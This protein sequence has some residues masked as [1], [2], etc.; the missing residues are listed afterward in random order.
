[1]HPSKRQSAERLEAGPGE[2]AVY[3]R[4]LDYCLDL[5]SH[6][7]MHVSHMSSIGTERW[8]LVHVWYMCVELSAGTVQTVMAQLPWG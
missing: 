1:M 3:C 5:C 6:T 7:A 4:N 2:Y 8:R